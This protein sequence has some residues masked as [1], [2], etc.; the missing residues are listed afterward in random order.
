MCPSNT[1]SSP[2]ANQDTAIFAAVY[3][4][5]LSREDHSVGA[6][7]QIDVDR[8]FLTMGWT[9]DADKRSNHQERTWTARHNLKPGIRNCFFGAAHVQE[10]TSAAATGSYPIHSWLVQL[11]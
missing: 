2:H 6:H 4:D 9:G 1:L 10:K 7:T 5:A 8:A 11:D 3:V